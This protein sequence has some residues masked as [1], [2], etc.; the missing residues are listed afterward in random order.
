MKSEHTDG[1]RTEEVVQW[2][3]Y[4]LG[5][6]SGE[7]KVGELTIN[8]RVKVCMCVHVGKGAR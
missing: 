5:L 4:I 7:L 8:E 6:I 3:V 1:M 2:H